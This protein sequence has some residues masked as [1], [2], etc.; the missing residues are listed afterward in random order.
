MH[1]KIL[2]SGCPKCKKLEESTKKAL[3]ELKKEAEITKVTEIQDIMGYGVM[4]TP[5]LV[6][7]E[8]VV[9]TGAVPDVK[10]II[11]RRRNAGGIYHAGLC[12]LELKLGLL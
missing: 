6:V 8:K 1:I 4:S 9:M 5:A 2:G 10:E 7:D 3:N 12:L 11:Y